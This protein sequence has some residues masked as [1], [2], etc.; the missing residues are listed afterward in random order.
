ML[1]HL[2]IH[3]HECSLELGS[4]MDDAPPAG[5]RLRDAHVF[6]IVRL[7]TETLSMRIVRSWSQVKPVS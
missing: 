7:D 4:G 1:L 2:A 5:L 6:V 3:K